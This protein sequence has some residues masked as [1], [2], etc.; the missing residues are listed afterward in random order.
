VT[1]VDG[2]YVVNGTKVFATS[3]TAAQWAILL[4]NLDG[5]GGVRHA[6]GPVDS[7][8]LLCCDLSDPSVTADGSWWNPIGMRATVSY[9]VRF[10]DTFIADAH[11]IGYPGQYIKEAWQTC[12]VPHYA[13]TFVGASEAA[14]ELALDYVTGQKKTA[15]PYV[16]HHIAAMAINIE[17]AH[18]W[19]RHVARLW[20][21]GQIEQA[22][23]AGSRARHVIEHLSEDVV[24]RCIRACGARSLNRPSAL[25]R[26]YRDLSFYVRHDNDDHILATI[27]RSLLGQGHDPSFFSP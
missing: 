16:Q 27:G 7:Q 24:K 15:D 10:T 1:K 18:L 21:S 2:G 19:L 23:I 3:A 5:P 12:F 11:S 9:L 17:T 22:Q 6:R 26:I 20:E 25:E 13:A 14:Y 4:V 8:R